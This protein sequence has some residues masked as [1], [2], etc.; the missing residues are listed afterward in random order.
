[1]DVQIV[2]TRSGSKMHYAGHVESQSEISLLPA[3]PPS[4][5]MQP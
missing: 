1:M 5:Q 3:L 4:A 2:S